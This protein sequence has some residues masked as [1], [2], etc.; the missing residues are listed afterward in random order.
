MRRLQQQGLAYYQFDALAGTPGLAHGIFTRLGGSSENE[1][2]SLNVGITVGDNIANVH[3][4]RQRMAAAL[5]Y[6]EQDARTTWQ[7]H[8]ADVIVIRGRDPQEWPPPKADGIITAEINIPLVMRFADCVPLV[9]YD[10]VVRAIGM[11]HAGWRGTLAGIGPATVRAMQAAFGCSP[12]NLV[13]G[14]GPSIGPCCYEVGQ[15]VVDQVKATFG[16]VDDLILNSDGNGAKP[17]FDL[18]AANSRALKEAGVVT[19][20]VGGICTA[21]RTDEFFSHRAE[22]GKTGRF[23]AAI[24][25]TSRDDN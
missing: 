11:A 22:Q 5:G 18:W 25:L 4:N 15:D 12:E 20:E 23:G 14:I 7:V 8:S 2:Q 19:V 1:F 24:M 6:G 17:H 16:N 10:P 13:V 21:S 3:A 9:F